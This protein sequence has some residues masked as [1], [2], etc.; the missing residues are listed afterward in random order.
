MKFNVT[1]EGIV[2]EIDALC[3]TNDTSYPIADKTRRINTALETVVSKILKADGK[4]Q[5][6]DENFTTAPT[7]TQD[8]VNAQ[9]AYS[10]TDKILQI[11]NVK[12]LDVNGV[13]QIVAPI[14]QIET[15]GVSLESLYTTTGFPEYYDKRANTIKFY[16]S[17][18]ST[19]VTLTAG[20]KIEFKRTG[21]LF[22]VAD[23]TK[24]PGFA[25]VYHIIIAWMSALPYNKLF[26]AERV[27]QLE[28]DINTMMADIVEFYSRRDK[29]SEDVLTGVSVNPY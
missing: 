24:E 21:S 29:D 3:G 12:V 4:W 5:F 9:Q 14:D 16:P 11:E 25:S 28:R 10:Y 1:G 23:T 15:N 22:T 18:S 27:P 17:P 8:L 6:D 7:G 13:Y 19:Q 20:L 26:H 2:Q